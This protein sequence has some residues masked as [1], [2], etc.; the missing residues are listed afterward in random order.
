MIASSPK[1]RIAI[2]THSTNPRGGVVHALELADALTRLGHVA[3]VHAPDRTGKGFFRSSLAPTISVPASAI[4]GDVTS[5]VETRIA[6]Y[7]RHFENPAHRQFDVYHAQDGI[8]G[9]ALATLKQRGLIQG[10]VRTVHHVDDFSDARLRELDQRSIVL[11]D[12]LFVVSRMWQERLRIELAWTSTLVGNGVDTASYSPIA[13]AAD[14]ALRDRLGLREGPVLLSIGGIEQ[15]KNT[16]AI[17]DALC[18]VH[19]VRRSAQLVIAGGASL[20]DHGTY[21][22]QFRLRLQDAGLPAGAVIETGPLVDAEMPSLYR[23]ADALVFP[24]LREGF[25]LVV[26]EAMASGVPVVVSHI[27]PF[28]EYLGDDDVAWCDPH[29]AGSIAN[30][31]ISALC[32]PLR[33]RLAANGRMIAKRHDWSR[34]AEA[35]LPIYQS[36]SEVHYA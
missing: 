36:M 3:V 2:L 27:P 28:T 15:R 7:V 14:S 22:Q 35:H 10:Y 1:L 6:D 24:S 18:Q 21:Q 29:H 20:L 26:L 11:A 31:I 9:N 30:A 19:A 23:L 16:H 17:L 25:G 8:S 5:M 4:S 32:E 33:S 13:T 12:Q 34:T